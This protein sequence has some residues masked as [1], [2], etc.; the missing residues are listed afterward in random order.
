MNNSN[1]E[2]AR[3]M[4]KTSDHMIYVTYPILK[5]NRLLIRILEQINNA[6][7]Q[8]VSTIMQHE[9]AYKRIKIYNDSRI[10]IETF[11][12]KCAPRYG[13]SK[14]YIE[15]IKQI[16]VLMEKHKR[17]PME[18]VRQNKF[19]IMSDNLE[20]DNVTLDRLK[21]FLAIAKDLM[22]KTEMTM[23]SDKSYF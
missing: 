10:N 14:E 19:I 6:I 23:A 16:L 22:K 21:F 3:R 8:I 13:I 17:S 5:E 4:I 12:T 11:E 2:E 1:L 15:G 18:F 9:Y 7:F 20:T